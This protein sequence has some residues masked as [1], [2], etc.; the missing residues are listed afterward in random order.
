MRG[1]KLLPAAA[2]Q[3]KTTRFGPL[4]AEKAEIGP[5]DRDPEVRTRLGAPERA[6]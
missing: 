5:K 6:Y 2:T 3:R 1:A 4:G